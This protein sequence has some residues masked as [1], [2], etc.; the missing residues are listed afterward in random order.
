MLRLLYVLVREMCASLRS[1]L[2]VAVGLE[3]RGVGV[4]KVVGSLSLVPPLLAGEPLSTMQGL[5]PPDFS[6]PSY[7]N[8]NGHEGLMGEKAKNNNLVSGSEGRQPC[9]L[10]FSD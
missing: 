2:I 4:D 5:L 7:E 8:Q 1:G 3:V 6:F 9:S 10:R